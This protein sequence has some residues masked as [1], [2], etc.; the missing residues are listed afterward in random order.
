MRRDHRRHV[1]SDTDLFARIRPPS[2]ALG[3]RGKH[4]RVRTQHANGSRDH[5]RAGDGDRH[6]PGLRTADNDLGVFEQFSLAVFVRNPLLGRGT[7]PARERHRPDQRQVDLTTVI[8]PARERVGAT[9]F[10]QVV[11]RDLEKITRPNLRYA[12]IGIRNLAF[13]QGEIDA[14]ALHFGGMKGRE[15][16]HPRSRDRRGRRP[17]EDLTTG[18]RR[19]TRKCHHNRVTRPKTVRSAALHT[20]MG[21][22]RQHGGWPGRTRNWGICGPNADDARHRMTSAIRTPSKKG[23]ETGE[24]AGGNLPARGGGIPVPVTGVKWSRARS[25]AGVWFRTKL[26]GTSIRANSR[27]RNRPIL[28]TA[29]KFAGAVPHRR[30][31]GRPKAVRAGSP[32]VPIRELLS[33]LAECVRGTIATRLR[34]RSEAH[35]TPSGNSGVPRSTH[36][37]RSQQLIRKPLTPAWHPNIGGLL[38]KRLPG[39][40]RGSQR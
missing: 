12:R 35:I 30:S 23:R 29:A 17:F 27:S 25:S 14:R 11:D 37:S 34:F 33:K 26:R 19:Q 15:Q 10:V 32:H 38:N 21:A 9:G 6:H 7:R 5:H 40:R 8:D 28:D 24:V 13:Q 22:V 39:F 4:G 3:D 36:P 18:R 20:P 2:T 31:P 16:R 1:A